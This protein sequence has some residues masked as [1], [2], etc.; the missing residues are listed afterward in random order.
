MKFCL[1]LTPVLQSLLVAVL[2]ALLMLPAAANAVTLDFTRDE[3]GVTI[4]GTV[5][6]D[7]ASLDDN[8][9]EDSELTSWTVG[10]TGN[11]EINA[12]T[13]SSDDGDELN[14]FSF[15]FTTE[16][17]MFSFG[18]TT[19]PKIF[20]VY[21]VVSD[22]EIVELNNI[23]QGVGGGL[24]AGTCTGTW[25]FGN[26]SDW[27]DRDNPSG[28]GDYEGITDYYNNGWILNPSPAGIECRTVS[29]DV[30][31]DDTGEVMSAYDVTTGCICKKADQSDNTCNDYEA[32]YFFGWTPWLDRDNPSG[33][34]DYE[35]INAH[36]R[37]GK[38]GCSDPVNIQCRRISDGVDAAETGEIL[39]CDTSY[40]FKCKLD[41]N[42]G[43]CSD[44]E[45]RFYCTY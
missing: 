7:D 45:V 42:N 30:D 41:D 10:W 3:F 35:D 25:V 8:I 12:F 9:L 43:S 28:T 21:G 36:V 14:A 19:D 22:K 37:E 38:L 17:L 27:H 44:Y 13:L 39:T 33:T 6:A 29:G 11:D 5:T 24:C 15:D 20:V 4:S 26:I 16:D 1:K 23:F 34:G 40:G 18:D 2:V 32:R 31:A